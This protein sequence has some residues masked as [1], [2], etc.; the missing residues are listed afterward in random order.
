MPNSY[1]VPTPNGNFFVCKEAIDALLPAFV[2]QWQQWVDKAA[3]KEMRYRARPTEAFLTLEFP[4]AGQIL[5]TCLMLPFMKYGDGINPS[6]QSVC[7][8]AK[9]YAKSWFDVD[10]YPQAQRPAIFDVVYGLLRFVADSTGMIEFEVQP[11]IGSRFNLTL[12]VVTEAGIPLYEELNIEADEVL[13]DTAA[14]QPS[15][16]PITYDSVPWVRGLNKAFRERQTDEV[17]A[18][19]INA[20]NAASSVP[21]VIDPYLAEAFLAWKAL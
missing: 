5:S 14:L 13:S 19:F 12:A 7:A 18:S 1:V 10:S 17:N 8:F 16:F 6:P 3:A 11:V 15:K 2:E 4:D 20:A 9:L 21:F